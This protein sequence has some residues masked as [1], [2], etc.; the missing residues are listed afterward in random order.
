[1]VLRGILSLNVRLTKI[2]MLT[3]F[4]HGTGAINVL[5]LEI[6]PYDFLFTYS[7]IA[8]KSVLCNDCLKRH[9]G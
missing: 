5:V 2:R 3:K 8:Q 4:S 1:M 6:L 7:Q 9:I